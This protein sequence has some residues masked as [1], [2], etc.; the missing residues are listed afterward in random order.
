MAE[1]KK[2][3][4]RALGNRQRA[5][6]REKWAVFDAKTSC[7]PTY[8]KSLAKSKISAKKRKKKKALDDAYSVFMRKIKAT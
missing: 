8:E 4:E 2:P 5:G 1:K 7:A 3:S 6:D